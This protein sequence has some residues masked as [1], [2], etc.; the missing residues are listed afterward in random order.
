MIHWSIDW[1]LVDGMNT[2]GAVS[3]T[4]LVIE[5][6]KVQVSTNDPEHTE[7]ISMKHLAG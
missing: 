6:E 5:Q 4:G 3:A 2:N 7:H 1:N